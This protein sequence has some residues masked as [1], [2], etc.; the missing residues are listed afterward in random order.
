V[1][2]YRVIDFGITSKISPSKWTSFGVYSGS[3]SLIGPSRSKSY[4]NSVQF[5]GPKCSFE[6]E[7]GTR[8]RPS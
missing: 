2:D 7:Y 4:L 8:S 1:I 3:T 6:L 5:T